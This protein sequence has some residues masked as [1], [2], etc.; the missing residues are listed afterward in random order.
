MKI[1][2]RQV[3]ILNLDIF[4]YA[5]LVVRSACCSQWSHFSRLPEINAATKGVQTRHR[6]FL[7]VR[8]LLTY[9]TR[10][11]NTKKIVEDFYRMAGHPN[12]PTRY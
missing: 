10:W 6:S 7:K 9:G 12:P 11:L 5:L 3:P 4:S 1:F 2:L 8:G